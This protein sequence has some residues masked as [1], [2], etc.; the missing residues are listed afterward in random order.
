[1]LR[2]SDQG[3]EATACV[4]WWSFGKTVLATAVLRLVAEGRLALEDGL[5][6]LLQHRAGLSDYGAL[7]DYHAAV[8]RG[9]APWPADEMLAR[10]AGQSAPSWRYSNVGYFHL[11]TLIEAT[12][13]AP[14]DACW[15]GWL[16]ARLARTPEDLAACAGGNAAGYHP[17]W[18]YHGL[19]LGTP[20]AAAQF[21]HR[22][23]T[24][25]ILPADLLARMRTPFPLGEIFA[26]RPWRSTGYGFGLMIGDMAGAGLAIGH[27]G[28]G[29]GSVAAVYHFPAQRRTFAAFAQGEDEGAPEWDVARAMQAAAAP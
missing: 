2:A 9:E 16:D 14:L 18:V 26:H 17:G 1:M 11:R 3:G 7:P 20:L 13:G 24:G 25:D 6:R 8:A 29:P 5:A 28:A 12:T 19:L 10:M 22:L 23:L 21:L 15:D 4:P 27:S